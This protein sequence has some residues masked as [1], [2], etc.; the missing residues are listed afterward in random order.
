MSASVSTPSRKAAASRIALL[1]L[2]LAAIAS[3]VA[4]YFGSGL[5][6]IWW[7]TWLAPLPVLA[8]APRAPRWIAFA[9]SLAAWAVGSLNMWHYLHLVQ[10]PIPVVIAATLLPALIFA[11]AV[12]GFRTR[13]RRGALLEAALFVPALWVAYEYLYSVFSP[14]STFGNL[15][16]SQMDFLPVLQVASV[17]GI[18]GIS[19]SLM[20]FAAAVAAIASNRVA[21]RQRIVLAIATVVTFA[22]VFGYGAWRLRS[23]PASPSITVGLVA[24]DLKQNL[25]PPR[26]A[27]VTLYHEYAAQIDEL[28]AQ[29]AKLVLIPEK[30]GLVDATSLLAIDQLLQSAADRNRVMVLT[31]VL[32][33][34][35]LYNEARIYTPSTV[36][37]ISYDKHHLLPAFE[38]DEIPGVTRTHLDEPSGRWGVAICKDMDFPLLSRQYGNDEVGLLLVPAWDFDLDGWLHGRMAILRGVE[39]GFSIARAPKQGILTLTDDRGRVLAERESST[40]PFATLIGD[41]PVHHDRTLYARFGDWFAWLD[42]VLLAALLLNLPRLLRKANG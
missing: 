9:A 10:V 28:A 17:T 35:G 11:A 37:P 20:F 3:A 42:L 26:E 24:S 33:S 15:A 12:D 39:S 22:A 16:Y 40:A 8:F 13:V 34:P 31:G 23:A 38:S 32:K 2:A 1:G 21:R 4:L 5:H 30:T 6:P 29:G 27:A 41:I 25:I 18:W 19:D 7:L 14:H 36:A